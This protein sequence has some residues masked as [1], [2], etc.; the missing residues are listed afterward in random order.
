MA[1]YNL[2]RIKTDYGYLLPLRGQSPDLTRS[3]HTHQVHL[4]NSK[5]LGVPFYTGL[6]GLLLYFH[7]GPALSS[8]MRLQNGQLVTL[9]SGTVSALVA[10]HLAQRADPTGGLQNPDV[11]VFL[12]AGAYVTVQDIVEGWLEVM[13]A[14]TPTE[15]DVV[16]LKVVLTKQS[17]YKWT[18]PNAEFSVYLLA[19]LGRLLVYLDFDT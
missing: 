12:R 14:N 17:F 5:D 11:H 3:R 1:T 15:Q 8:S 7:K 16:G 19:W 9:G 13:E 4:R 2:P 18:F 10:A 6:V